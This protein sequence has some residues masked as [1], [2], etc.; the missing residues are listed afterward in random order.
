MENT[1]AMGQDH[2]ALNPVI[3]FFPGAARVVDKGGTRFMDVFDQDMFSGIQNSENIYYPFTN[4]PEWE[5]AEYLLTSEL[6]MATI[7]HFLSLTF[8]S[9][10]STGLLSFLGFTDI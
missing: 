1:P 4:R 9:C 6:S 10:F 7:D 8:V 3:D 2:E 5:L